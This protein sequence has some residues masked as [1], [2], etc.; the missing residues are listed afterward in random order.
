MVDNVNANI[1][2]LSGQCARF[3]SLFGTVWIYNM[4][5]NGLDLR[6]DLER[7]ESEWFGIRMVLNRNGFESEWF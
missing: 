7:L 1:H 6:Y 3:T 5:W 2:D 4:I